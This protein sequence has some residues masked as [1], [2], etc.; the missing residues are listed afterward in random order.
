MLEV[1]MK[2][3]E[4]SGESKSKKY[5]QAVTAILTLARLEEAADSLGVKY[6]TLWRWM[7]DSEMQNLLSDARRNLLIGTISGLQAAMGEAVTVLKEILTDAKTPPN[8]KV[9]AARIILDMGF[10]SWSAIELEERMNRLEQ[11]LNIRQ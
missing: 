2:G 11:A 8:V 9:S 3:F 7:Q 5:K 6:V 1:K 10:K 4:M